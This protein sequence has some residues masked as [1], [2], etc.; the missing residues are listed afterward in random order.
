M[1]HLYQDIY[2]QDDFMDNEINQSGY[3]KG[4][5]NGE[6]VAEKELPLTLSN[7]KFE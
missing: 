4:W 6:E 2:T 3:S 1:K 7:T 5:N